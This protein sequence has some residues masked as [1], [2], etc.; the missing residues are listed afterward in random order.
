MK[1]FFFSSIRIFLFVFFCC[2]LLYSCHSHGVKR[3][4]APQPLSVTYL[5]QSACFNSKTVE[6][7]VDTADNMLYVHLDMVNPQSIPFPVDPV[8]HDTLWRTA[9][10]FSFY[11]GDRKLVCK[12]TPYFTG[13]LYGYPV[14]PDSALAI[15]T[16]TL[17]L[18]SYRTF[19]FQIPLSCFYSL[20]HGRQTIEMEV[21]QT[22]FTNGRVSKSSGKKI[23]TVR[24]S[25]T[26][27]LLNARVKFDLAVPPVYKTMIYGLGLELRNDS[28]FNPYTMDNTLWKSSL[29]D[30]YWNIYYPRDVL[31]AKTPYESSTIRYVKH[32]TIAFYHYALLDSVGI[33]VWDHDFL[34]PDDG[35]GCWYGS[36]P[37][38][39]KQDSCLLVFGHI[40]H[41][42]LRAVRRGL[43]N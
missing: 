17:E 29:P 25:L 1:H 40:K 30:I 8:Y 14:Q 41:F 26:C 22:V 3:A 5:N 33:G 2:L 15:H 34:S 38:L 31:Y 42:K 7:G 16:D 32:D 12:Y 37:E 19:E 39:E 20:K 21:G 24:P 9:F 23:I 27:P 28:T 35:M 4:P 13:R 18:T 11:S 10:T 43:V 36:L 6:L